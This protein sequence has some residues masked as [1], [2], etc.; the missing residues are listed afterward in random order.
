MVPVTIAGNISGEATTPSGNTFNDATRGPRV[1][2]VGRSVLPG[3]QRRA[4]AP[5][6]VRRSRPSRHGF[7]PACGAARNWRLVMHR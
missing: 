3:R 7:V 1:S 6:F 5:S 4:I 2:I